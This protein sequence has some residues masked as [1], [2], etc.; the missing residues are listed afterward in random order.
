MKFCYDYARPALTVDCLVLFHPRYKEL[1]LLLVHRANAPF[2]E[3]WALPGGF[4]GEHEDLEIAARRELREETQLVVNRLHQ[5]HT[6]GTIGRDPRAHVVS[7]VYY[8]FL[9]KR[10]PAP[11]AGADAKAV[12]WFP[13]SSLPQL[14]FDHN[15]IIQYA[16]RSQ[17]FLNHHRHST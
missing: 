2:A 6:F 9:P 10:T 11:S 17:S 13:V 12:G 1:Q 7:V 4:V 3:Q 16:F 8:T 5:L 15:A 14:A